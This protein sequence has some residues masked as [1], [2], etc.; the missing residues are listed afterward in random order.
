MNTSDANH[1]FSLESKTIARHF[2]AYIK[3]ASWKGTENKAY[4]ELS[5]GIGFNIYYLSNYDFGYVYV[6]FN[7]INY[8][9]SIL[10]LREN[11]FI[12]MKEWLKERGQNANNGEDS[13]F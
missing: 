9:Y 10:Y 1:P 12:H 5:N 13:G 3:S 4:I 6:A 11:M 8:N 2:N 7:N